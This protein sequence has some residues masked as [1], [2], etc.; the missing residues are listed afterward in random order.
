[1]FKVLL[2]L[3]IGL[4][5]LFFVLSSN[6]KESLE[7]NGQL[8][9][10]SNHRNWDSSDHDTQGYSFGG[11]LHIQAQLFYGLSLGNT[12]FVANDFGFNPESSLNVTAELPGNDVEVLGES[13]LTFDRGQY[14]FAAGR[15]VIDTPFAN[16]SEHFMI[17]IAFHAYS[18]FYKF[19]ESTKLRLLFLD[20]IKDRQSDKFV[21]LGEFATKRFKDT[22]LNSEGVYVFSVEHRKDN[23]DI[24]FWG[25]RFSDMMDF[26]FLQGG[27]NFNKETSLFFQA[28]KQSSQ[29]E[30]IL[31]KDDKKIDASLYGF[32]IAHKWND[33]KP[34]LAFV[35]VPKKDSALKNGALVSPFTFFTS[36]VFTNSFMSGMENVDSGS[37]LKARLD[38]SLSKKTTLALEYSQFQF[39]SDKTDRQEIDVDVH[40]KFSGNYDGLSLKVRTASVKTQENSVGVDALRMQLQYLF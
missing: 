4:T 16:A 34:S 36:P 37:S 19:S 8:R 7:A 12:F 17:P 23:Y 2:R 24:D 29:G 20:R 11:K 6:S 22:H 33:F 9:F 18:A 14:G 1:M 3:F 38:Y 21:N 15:Q 27:Y 26:L 10:Y 28:A 31:D 30:G 5:T 40:H 39:T 25:Y 35:H 32:K 13:Y